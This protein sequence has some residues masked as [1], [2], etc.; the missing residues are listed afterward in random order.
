MTRALVVGNSGSGKSTL[1]A[2]L[3][4]RDGLAHLDL[5]PL[6]WLPTTPPSRR[7]IAQSAREI[8]AF[9]AAHPAW[10]IEGCYAD[11]LDLVTAHATRL[12]FLNPGVEACIANARA[13]PWEPHKYASKEA[14]DRNLDM[15]IGWIR[16]YETR[17]D[18]LSLSAHRRL[19]DAFPGDKLEL[20]SRDAIAGL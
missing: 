6:A 13:R 4:Q 11:L 18:E 3:A 14:Q 9:I 17:S 12:V 8:E 16:G 15:L 1:A 7:P 10:V 19:F 5:D 2:R 20:T